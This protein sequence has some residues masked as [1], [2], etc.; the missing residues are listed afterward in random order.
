M[1]EGEEYK[2]NPMAA[3]QGGLPG[4]LM[5]PTDNPP[6]VQL[7][8]PTELPKIATQESE[9]KTTTPEDL[10]PKQE[11]AQVRP[12]EEPAKSPTLVTSPEMV[13]TP[14]VEE[15]VMGRGKKKGKK[16][17]KKRRNA[18]N[19]TIIGANQ[20]YEESKSNHMHKEPSPELEDP[21][22]AV[23]ETAVVEMNKPLE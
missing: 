1:K 9:S 19:E 4:T 5:A 8:I 10:P 11:Q 12:F 7:S 21:I 14:E 16:K 17:K 23:L 2:M 15:S 13:T 22:A 18:N 3:N 20:S 6:A